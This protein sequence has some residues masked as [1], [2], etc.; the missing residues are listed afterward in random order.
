MKNIFGFY[1]SGKTPRWFGRIF[2]VCEEEK[3]CHSTDCKFNSAIET[4]NETW[5]IFHDTFP[6]I[7]VD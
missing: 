3:F 2:G 6:D 4:S 5:G 1:F 7:W